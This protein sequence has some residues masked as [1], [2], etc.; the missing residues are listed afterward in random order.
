MSLGDVS[1]TNGDVPNPMTTPD[2][3][4]IEQEQ[5]NAQDGTT[6]STTDAT[7]PSKKSSKKE[8]PQVQASTSEQN[9]AEAGAGVKLTGA[10]LKKQKAAEKAAR[11]AEKVALKGA[12]QI[13]PE[14]PQQ[15]ADIQQQKPSQAETAT[16]KDGD[17]L[18]TP[19]QH[20]KRRG[21]NQ[22]PLEPGAVR[23]PFR[24]GQQ[25]AS[26][27]QS[28]PQPQQKPADKRVP[29]VSHLYPSARPASLTTASRE[30]HPSVLTLALHLR[31]LSLAGSTARTLSLLLTL[32]RVIR[33]YTTPP[34][35]ALSRHLTI[36][37][38]HQITFLSS[39]RP[40]GVAQ[41]NAIRWLKKLIS[42]LDPD[43]DDADAKRFL[44]DAIDG[45][46][47]EKI[48]YA[49][50]IIAEQASD[51]LSQT[52]E[53]ILVYGKSSLVE[54]TL[55]HA[56]RNDH[57][58]FRVIVVDSRPLFEGRNLAKSLLRA[59]MH[60][61]GDL[62]SC[63]VVYTLISG[64]SNVL[65]QN[66]VTKCFLG[67]SGVLGNGTLYSRSGTAMVAMMAR[68]HKIPVIVLG[69]SIKFTA[70]MVVDSLSMNEIGDP[71]ALIEREQSHVFTDLSSQTA[72]KQ[73][74][75]QNANT[76]KGPTKKK[77]EDQKEQDEAHAK[78]NESLLSGWHDQQGLYLLNL[79]YDVTPREYL[80]MV[81]CELG[82]LPPGGV[83]VVNGVHGAEE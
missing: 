81:I 71:D 55:L 65:D 2:Q 4:A 32:K 51:R 22:P 16:K 64:L 11:R 72:T 27:S 24:P 50:T 74:E 31:S 60:D 15:R 25:P 38:S 75:S 23:I 44:S 8:R 6:E 76:K 34:S 14:K 73:G 58:K 47:V 78:N 46:I 7:A 83:P 82:T 66:T 10:A 12:D 30:I 19:T 33:A 28:Q 39:A 52:G 29:M 63:E 43:L 56:A 37:L 70:K 77:E 13:Q 36:H 59:G 9:I 18:Q 62:S 48:T 61:G 3:D 21:S 54:K 5:Q 41:G 53:T 80:D 20:H 45:F 17:H 79:M 1:R 69:E 67:A 57:K 42:Q 35:T 40:L 49:S 68:Q 26:T